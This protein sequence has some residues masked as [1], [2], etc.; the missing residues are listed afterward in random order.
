MH[1]FPYFRPYFCIFGYFR[2]NSIS[3][4]ES[5]GIFLIDIMK[6]YLIIPNDTFII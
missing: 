6:W 3:F 5:L 4:G 1:F 2:Q